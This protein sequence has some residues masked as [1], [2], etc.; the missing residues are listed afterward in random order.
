MSLAIP[1]RY[2]TGRIDEI[3]LLFL[4]VIIFV[5]FRS[6]KK[7]CY[8]F[9]SSHF[10]PFLQLD[11]PQRQK[12]TASTTWQPVGSATFSL[13]CNAPGDSSPRH[14]TFPS[15]MDWIIQHVCNSECCCIERILVAG[16]PSDGSCHGQ[17]INA[18]YISP[19][20]FA[21][22][23]PDAQYKDPSLSQDQFFSW[24]DIYIYISE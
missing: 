12:T 11:I 4:V 13:I 16:S 1:E 17:H 24:F 9:I 23:V 21:S 18:Y 15:K 20:L 6:D 22:A 3:F 5:V 14:T 19:S 2:S 10:Q 7:G 8:F